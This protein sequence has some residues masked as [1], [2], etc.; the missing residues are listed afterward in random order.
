MLK[1]KIVMFIAAAMMT[2]SASSAFAAFADLE[3]IRVVYERGTGTTEQVTDLGNVNTIIADVKANGTKTFTGATLTTTAGNSANLYAAYFAV[4]RTTG[5]LWVSGS[6]DTTLAPVAVGSPGFS[7]MKSGVLPMYTYYN[8]VLVT[9]DANGVKTG[10]QTY[11]S[12]YVKKLTASQGSLGNAIDIAT[13]PNTE[14]SLASLVGATSGS[15]TQ[16]LYKLNG[17]IAGDVGLFTDA[18]SITTNFNGSTTVSST[19][20]PPA[21]FLM[22]SGLLGM[23]GLRRKNKVA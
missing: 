7:V 20:I 22:G 11:A 4:N 2:L 5:D 14:I 3:L 8:G 16:S 23:F 13:R 9:T 18:I 10:S 15:V 12:S 6:T 21:F 17:L 1:K 19:P